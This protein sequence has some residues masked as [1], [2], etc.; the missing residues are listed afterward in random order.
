MTSLSIAALIPSVMGVSLVKIFILERIYSADVIS[1]RVSWPV[2]VRF[3]TWS[4][5]TRFRVL[6]I[7]LLV[8]IFDAINN[9]GTISRLDFVFLSKFL[10]HMDVFKKNESNNSVVVFFHNF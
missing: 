8:L 1:F 10:S 2:I 7:S 4:N 6:F 9:E 3:L 5:F